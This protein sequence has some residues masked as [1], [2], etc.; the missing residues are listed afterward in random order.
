MLQLGS[1]LHACRCAGVSGWVNP[2]EEDAHTPVFGGRLQM[3][4][5]DVDAS[6]DLGGEYARPV[7]GVIMGVKEAACI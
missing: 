5:P 1:G 4:L 7:S 3:G 2:D 6:I